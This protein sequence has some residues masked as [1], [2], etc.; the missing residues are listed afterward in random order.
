ML[1]GFENLCTDG[2]LPYS[3]PWIHSILA[4][5]TGSISS[6]LSAYFRRDALSVC[7]T[8]LGNIK[9]PKSASVH[10][11]ILNVLKGTINRQPIYAGE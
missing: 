9:H 11:K 2:Y 7:F 5:S 3:V 8:M 6:F 1:E 4:P 10:P